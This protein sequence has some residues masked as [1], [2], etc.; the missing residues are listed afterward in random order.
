MPTHRP[1]AADAGDSSG[2]MVRFCATSASRYEELFQYRSAAPRAF[3]Q[4]G[5]RHSALR[6]RV[7]INRGRGYPG[8]RPVT[9][10]L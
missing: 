8:Q 7:G 9:L 4:A 3:S 6:C 1:L 2:Q 10:G 5:G